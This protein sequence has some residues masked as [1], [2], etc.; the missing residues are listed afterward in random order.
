MV[1]GHRPSADSRNRAVVA[2]SGGRPHVTLAARQLRLRGGRAARVL[3]AEK[4]GPAHRARGFPSK[5]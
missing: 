1:S 2:R 5:P 4:S 3:V